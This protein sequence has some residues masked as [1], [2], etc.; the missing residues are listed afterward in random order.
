MEHS[1]YFNAVS[2][3]YQVTLTLFSPIFYILNVVSEIY[4]YFSSVSI[5]LNLLVLF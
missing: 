4:P 3:S 1:R 5:V 2:R